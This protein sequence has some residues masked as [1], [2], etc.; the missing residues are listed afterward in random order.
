MVRGDLKEVPPCYS[1]KS[2]LVKRVSLFTL[3]S[4]C[5]SKHGWLSV[6]KV[7]MELYWHPSAHCCIS[8]SACVCVKVYP[9]IIPS[10][11]LLCRLIPQTCHTS[12]PRPV[13]DDLRVE[14]HIKAARTAAEAM[15]TKPRLLPLPFLFPSLSG[16]LFLR[17]HP[18]S[19][20]QSC[21]PLTEPWH[22]FSASSSC[23]AYLPSSSCSAWQSQPS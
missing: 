19:A 21:G 9:P 17:S 16:H 13:S 2:F 23:F 4:L 10:L 15:I 18:S 1:Q 8:L 7:K 14:E 22:T 6:C 5:S 12:L 3:H 11:L 20:S